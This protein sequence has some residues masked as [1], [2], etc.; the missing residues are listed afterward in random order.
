MATVRAMSVDSDDRM[1]LSARV[2]S[3]VVHRFAYAL[4]VLIDCQ[5]TVKDYTKYFNTVQQGYG[6]T[7]DVQKTN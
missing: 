6:T 1:C 3:V 7:S 4:Y 5:K 2:W